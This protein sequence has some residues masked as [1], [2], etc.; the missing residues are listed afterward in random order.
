MELEDTNVDATA[1]AF[2]GD[3]SLIKQ[4]LTRRPQSKIDSLDCG[5]VHY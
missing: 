4:T 2:N 1:K 5:R 3:L